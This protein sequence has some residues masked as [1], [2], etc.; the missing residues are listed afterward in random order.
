MARTIP[1]FT[2]TRPSLSA[3]L[4]FRV[5]PPLALYVHVP[6]CV[7]K[8]PYCDFNSH[9]AGETIPEREYVDA[10]IADL[11]SALPLI[12]GRPVVSVFFGGGTPSLLSPAA[13][14]E[15]LAAFRALAMLAPDAEI[16]LE[17]NPGTVEAEKFAGFRAAGVNR[18]S[19][20]IQSFND[21]HLKAL[22]RIH[23]AAEARLAA[24]LAG[25]HFETFNLDLM[26]GL[27]GQTMAQALGDVEAALSLSPTHLSCYQLTLEPNTRFAAFPPELPEGDLCADMQ[28]AIEARLSAAGFANYETSAFALPGRQCK[29]NLN[30][31]YFGDYLGIGAGAHSKLTLHDRVL[32]QMRH[33]HPKAYL[34][35]IRRGN[36]VQEHN[37]VEAASLPFEFMMN[38]LRLADGFH[39][40]L[41]EARTARSLHTILPQLNAAKAEGLLEVGPEKIAPTLKGRRFLNVLLERFL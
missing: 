15:L 6:W 38:A 5:S 3:P 27:P 7:Q 30:Y 9:E 41:F 19:L 22:G 26:Y 4:E 31:W 28:E 40:S 1:I 35:N 33:K 39:P 37:E 20:G 16:T 29:H 8:C 36:A 13:I 25:E 34:D 32:R 21:A 18:L 24:Q 14:D 12:W 2:D 23:D 11:Q 17:A 10:L